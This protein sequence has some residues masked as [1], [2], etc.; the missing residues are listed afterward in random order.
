VG[1]AGIILTGSRGASYFLGDFVGSDTGLRAVVSCK[2]GAELR[3]RF[4]RPVRVI[5]LGDVIEAA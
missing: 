2:T 4:S 5:V 3:D 1:P